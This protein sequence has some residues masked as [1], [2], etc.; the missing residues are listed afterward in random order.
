MIAA[1]ERYQRRQ[2]A[3]RDYRSPPGGVGGEVAQGVGDA[4]LGFQV[5]SICDRDEWG[6]GPAPNDRGLEVDV[7]GDIAQGHGAEEAVGDVG[8]A[9]ERNQVTDVD[10][11]EKARRVLADAPR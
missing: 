1:R 8:R 3:F 7:G 5:S 11:L 4:P 9:Q 6:E 2:P 10:S